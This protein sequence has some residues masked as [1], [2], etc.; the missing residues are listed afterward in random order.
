MRRIFN[1]TNIL[2][3]A[4]IGL[5]LLLPA[6]KNSEIF[7]TKELIG[8]IVGIEFLYILNLIFKKDE[9]KRQSIGDVT[10]IIYGCIMIWELLTTKLDVLHNLLFPMPGEVVA[11][12]IS[13]IPA[14]L[15]G[16]VS[17]LKLLVIGYI[18]AL[19][20]AIPLA[21][22]IGWRKRLFLTVNPLTKVLGPIP[23]I[24]YIP[25]AIAI[26][27]NFKSAS[28]FIIF[29]GAFWPIFINTLNG[30]FNIDKR[31]IDS[32]KVLNVKEQTM[33]FKIIL[34]GVLPSIISGTTL[35]LVLS[36][37][38]LTSAEMI[39]AS[40]GL[41]WYVKYF[42]DFAD[43]PRVVVGIIFIGMVVTGITHCFDK[44]EKQLLR[45]KN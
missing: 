45:W 40:S 17:S 35:G 3:A 5:E 11:V 15:E 4:I 41:G 22:I 31:I 13:E 2:F 6:K 42:S 25:Y 1:I 39:G 12:F 9:K 27:P 21:L 7:Y 32:A 34:P 36:F 10:A 8:M 18:L 24:V 26:L 44:I 33:L 37:I 28:I 29:I 20:T 16:L 14:L 30:T 23:P 43:Y 19:V 38:L